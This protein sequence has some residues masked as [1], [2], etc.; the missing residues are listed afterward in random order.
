MP[1][2]T[3]PSKKCL[4]FL[5]KPLFELT[6]AIAVAAGPKLRAVQVSAIFT[7]MRVLDTQ[8]CEVFF[9]KITFFRQWRCT[10]TNFDPSYRTITTKPSVFHVFEIFV[11]GDGAVSQGLFIDGLQES[12]F[13]SRLQPRWGRCGSLLSKVWQI[14]RLILP[15]I[16]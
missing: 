14:S 3:E 6:G 1:D 13:L 16:L 5:S 10:E 4:P 8:Q 11:A 9:P 12:Q 2:Q 7:R 15:A